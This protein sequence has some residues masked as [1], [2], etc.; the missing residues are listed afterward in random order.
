MPP[1]PYRGPTQMTLGNSISDNASAPRAGS[2]DSER[3]RLTKLLRHV[4]GLVYELRQHP[5]GHFCLPYASENLEDIYGVSLSDVA[6]DIAPLFAAIHR[7]DR[8]IVWESLQESLQSLGTWHS[9]HRVN[10]ADGQ[11]LWVSVY[12]TPERQPDGGTQWY[13]Y[14]ENVTPLQQA[15]QQSETKLRRIID[16]LNE[17]VFIAAPDGTFSFVSSRLATTLGYSPGE[18]LHTAFTPLVHPEDLPTYLEVFQSVLAGE[19]VQDYEYRVRHADGHYY[20]H[21][22]NLSPFQEDNGETACLGESSLIHSRK[23][24][25]ASKV[26]QVEQK[27][28]LLET[29]F[30]VVL[31]GY[32]EWDILNDQAYFSPGFN[33]IL[34]Y[35]NDELENYRESWKRLIFSD[36]LTIVVQNLENHIQSRGKIPFYHQTRYHHK[37]GSK[38]W[39]LCYGQVI[40]WDSNGNP[41]R[42]IGCH[43]DISDQQQAQIDLIDLSSQ[44]KKTQEIARL[45]HWSFDVTTETFTWSEEIFR[46]FNRSLD[47]GEPSFEEFM[48][49][50]HPEDRARVLKRLSAARQG[51]SQNLD[52]RIIRSD[53]RI[54]HVNVRIELEF[55]DEQ[56]VGMFGIL[57]DITERVE[58]DQASQEAEAKLRSLF[59]LSPLGIALNDMQGQFIEANPAIT[60]ITGYTLEELNQLSYWEL[61]PA[62]YEEDEARQLELLKTIGRYGPYEKEYIHKQGHRVPVELNGM[63]ITGRDGQ[64]YIWSMVADISDRKQAEALRVEQVN[65]ELKLLENILEVVLG[66]YWDWDI[67]NNQEYLSPGFKQMLGYEDHE[68]PNSPESWQRL[69]FSEDL[70]RV[71]QQ[72]E[73]HIQSRGEIPFYNEVR[74]HHKD[75]STVWVLCHGRVIEWDDQDNPL[76]MIG[77]HIDISDRKQAELKLI[78]LSNQLKKAQEVA[79][80]GHWSFDVTTGKIIW[81]EEVFRIFSHPLEQGEPSFEE[82]VQQIYSEDRT[83]FLERIAAANEGLPQNFDFR[84]MRSD[85]TFGY[86]NARIELEVEDEQVVQMFGVVMDITDRR[87]AE[88][89]LERFFTISLDLLCIADTG[90]HFCRVSQAWSDILGY[91]PADLEGR[92]FLEFV[93]PDDLASTLAAISTLKEGQP[94]MRFTNRYR[95]KSGSYRHIEWLSLPQGELIYAAARDITERIEAQEQLESLLNRTQLLNALS[96]EIRQSLELD[97]I[98]QRTV[99]AVF[100]ELDLDICTFARHSEEDGHPYVEIVQEKRKSSCQSWLGIYDATQYPDYH[101]A[102]LTNQVFRFNRQNPGEDCDR[103]IY[104]FCESMGVNLYLMLPIQ[105]TDQLACLEM[106]RI[107]GSR[108]WR[109]DEIELLESL[110][111]QVAIAMQQ[112]HLYQTAQQ[113]T[114]E[115]QVAYRDLQEAQVQLVQ[116]EKMSSLGQL[117]AG[118]AHEINNPVSFI[119]GNLD[120]LGDYVEGLLDI[121]ETYQETYPEPLIELSELI[122]DLDLPFIAED[123]PKMVNSMRN[124]A[125]RIRDIVKSLRT[126]S[127]LDEADLKAADLHENLDSTLMILQNQL[128]GRSGKPKIEVIKNY[129]DLPLVEC[130][131]GL[132]NQVFMN[133]LVNAIQAIEDRQNTEGNSMGNSSYQGVITITTI[134]KEAGEVVISVQDNG[135]GMS[136]QVKEKIFEPF[137]TTKPIGSG[138]GMGLPTSHQIVTKYHEGELYFDSTLGGGTT[139]FVRLPRCNPSATGEERQ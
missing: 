13:G 130:Y 97:Q 105:T 23:Q 56:V 29:I 57:M 87:V 32:W 124:G 136:E 43:L 88:L 82:H 80:L 19:R 44:L 116:A 63:L 107:D 83:H 27:S 46:I 64:D 129:G 79:Q 73:N 138:T 9:T 98:V 60:E 109:Q 24:A 104:D 106:A 30:D 15:Q 18:L 58:A 51:I 75:G 119:Y 45:G 89:E 62:E 93:H 137:F 55:Q 135:L 2:L 68:L 120:P 94:V 114:A 115:L 74:Y 3:D 69:V 35:E 108:E 16:N 33:R 50:I 12:G 17:M 42:M 133:V 49:Q 48:E 54:G 78:E 122:E 22:V 72:F 8:R 81:S 95:T 86:L 131:I 59:D 21:S 7:A 65:R 70:T 85:G 100:D 103:G 112:A 40:D 117:V 84:I 67:P 96:N 76:R 113:R 47:Q 5:D 102:L 20:W 31:A 52:H 121:I 25:E 4:P 123:L 38:V 132:L 6:V 128:N 10:Q 1:P 39:L 101:K 66:G 34:G 118:I 127:R 134:L 26:E 37:D 139:F 11:C 90:G 14:L 92:V 41:L 99:E 71:F 91:S 36:D 53:G 77:C 110:G 28:N 126:F 111:L 125:D 61:T